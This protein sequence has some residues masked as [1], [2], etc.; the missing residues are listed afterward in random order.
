[1]NGY[2]ESRKFFAHSDILVPFI[3]SKSSTRPDESKERYWLTALLNHIT[4][5]AKG[6]CQIARNRR[7]FGELELDGSSSTRPD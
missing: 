3:A 5:G 6:C 2:H 4:A 7:T 1:M